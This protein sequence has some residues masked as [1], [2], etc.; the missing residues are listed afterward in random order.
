M[1]L[2][3]TKLPDFIRRIREASVKNTPDMKLEIKGMENVQS[4]KLQSLRTGRIVNAV[5][6]MAVSEGVDHMEI[7]IRPR[8][9]ETMHTVIIKGYDKDG[10][11]KKAIVETVDMLVPTEELDLFDCE[12]VIDRRPKMTVYSKI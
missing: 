3:H 2:M 9:P 8:M 5:E 7:L 6:E 10:K 12:E 1:R 4:A 11:A